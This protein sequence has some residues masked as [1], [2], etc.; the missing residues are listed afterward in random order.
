[1]AGDKSLRDLTNAQLVEVWNTH[2]A[3]PG[4]KHKRLPSW[5]GKKDVL[6]ARILTAGYGA[7]PKTEK[8]PEP[9]KSAPA[10]EQGE[11]K[12]TVRAASLELLCRVEYYE[13]KSRGPSDDNR[14]AEAAPDRRSVGLPYDEILKA[15]TA[16]FPGAQTSVACL[17]WYAVKVRVED[18]G[19]ENLRLPQRRPRVKPSTTE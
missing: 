13:E 17:R 3:K 14:F 18:A 4:S 2:V 16:E 1:M 9:K 6:V 8:K 7:A 15:I 10:K 11:R 19:Y 12:R 5:K